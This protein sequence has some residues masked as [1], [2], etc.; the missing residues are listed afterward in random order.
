MYV[1]NVVAITSGLAGLVF[2]SYA[3]INE[4]AKSKTE[5]IR[6]SELVHSDHELQYSIEKAMTFNSFDKLKNLTA[7]SYIVVL[8]TADYDGNVF[9]SGGGNLEP[10]GTL[11]IKNS[12]VGVPSSL[13]IRS[14]PLGWTCPCKKNYTKGGHWNNIY[15]YEWK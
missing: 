8:E 4:R 5:R 1:V 10:G 11:N 6:A 13:M 12:E 3:L 9:P 2:G 14:S 15:T 7:R